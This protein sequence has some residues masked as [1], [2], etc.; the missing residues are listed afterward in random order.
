MFNRFKFNGKHKPTFT[1]GALT[2]VS[3]FTLNSS[4]GI[5]STYIIR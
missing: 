3:K 4:S 1:E 2:E 5:T